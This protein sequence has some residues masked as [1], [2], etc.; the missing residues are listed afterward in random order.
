LPADVL[1]EVIDYN[2]RLKQ[3]FVTDESGEIVETVETLS[4]EL[5]KPAEEV[6]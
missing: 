4:R 5:R 1:V 6:R 2:R 3:R